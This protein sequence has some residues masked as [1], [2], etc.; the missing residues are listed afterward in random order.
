MSSK[1][2]HTNKGSD[3]VADLAS[4]IKDKTV[5]ITGT[6]PGGIGALYAAA[7]A[8]ASPAL[9]IMTGRSTASI[10]D[11]ADAVAAANPAV[12]ARLVA[13][14]LSSLASAQAAASELMGASDVPH[15]DVL[16]LNAGIMTAP[17]GRTAEGFEMQFGVNHLGHFVFANAV[18]PKVLEAASPRVVVVSSHG[19]RLSPIRWGDVSFQA[20]QHFP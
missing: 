9:I 3:L 8:R 2:D 20:S 12:E 4:N 1:Y 5:L 7:I 19:H 15:I 18:M 6:S 10:Q 14:D 17:Y 11:T 16:V 13:M